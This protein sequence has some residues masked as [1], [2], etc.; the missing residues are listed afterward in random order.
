[1]KKIRWTYIGYNPFFGL[2]IRNLFCLILF[3]NASI[4]F[5]QIKNTTDTL[6]LEVTMKSFGKCKPLPDEFYKITG[7][8]KEDI[9]SAFYVTLN[10][11]NDIITV[12]V[13]DKVFNYD[14]FYKIFTIRGWIIKK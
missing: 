1:M 7:L 5:G 10:K 8:K 4:S 11:I 9:T 14:C 2:T 12:P 3:I 13:N 6:V